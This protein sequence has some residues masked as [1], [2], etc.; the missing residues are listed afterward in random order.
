[1]SIM[2]N[3]NADLLGPLLRR[4]G[5]P[6]MTLTPAGQSSRCIS[7]LSPSVRD[8]VRHS[9]SSRY[10]SQSTK[11][12]LGGRQGDRGTFSSHW[13]ELAEFLSNH[14]LLYRPDASDRFEN[15]LNELRESNACLC[16]DSKSS[17]T[18]SIVS[19]SVS[20]TWSAA[21]LNALSKW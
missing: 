9:R 12:H 1:M 4:P 14:L 17:E 19:S 8:R 10:H 15:F 6:V 11:C 7:M 16:L 20:R 5:L 21:A 3:R 2:F 13:D 18:N